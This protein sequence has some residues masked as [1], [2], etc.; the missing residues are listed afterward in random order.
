VLFTETATGESAIRLFLE[1]TL[2]HQEGAGPLEYGASSF[3]FWTHHPGL[4][5]VFQT[6]LLGDTSLFKLSFLMFA[7]F[8]LS[9]AALTKGRS[10]AQLAAL[11]AAAAAAVQLWK[12]HATGSY[13][14]WYLPFLMIALFTQGGIAVT[15]E[16]KA[17]LDAEPSATPATV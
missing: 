8:C 15:G 12:T 14:E 10:P 16:G 1:S 5:A 4:A 9:L 11:T 13:V 7:G 3:S 2:E 6:P 17:G